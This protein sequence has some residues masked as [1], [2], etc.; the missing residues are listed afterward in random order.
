MVVD[1][2]I[3]EKAGGNFVSEISDASL[4]QGN[5]GYKKSTWEQ[6]TN[7]KRYQTRVISVAKKVNLKFDEAEPK[8]TEGLIK[9]I[10]GL[11]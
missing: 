7:W 9:S 5:S 2:Q 3:S 8:L 10:S 11:L 6:K 1:L 4:K